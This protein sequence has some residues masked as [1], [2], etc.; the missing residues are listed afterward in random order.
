MFV[1]GA[2]PL[3]HYAVKGGVCVH[4]CMCVRVVV[5]AYITYHITRP[6]YISY[7]LY[8]LSL[9]S[10][11]TYISYHITLP[12]ADTPLSLNEFLVCVGRRFIEV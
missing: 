12:A 8:Q 6:T 3:L 10:V 11:I 9:I 4:A 2:T 5:I 1:V 7:H